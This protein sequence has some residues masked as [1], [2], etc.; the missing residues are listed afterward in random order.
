MEHRSFS[1]DSGT[2]CPVCAHSCN[3]ATSVS[4]LDSPDSR[5]ATICIN[6]S[7]VLLFNK[8][9]TLREPT[10]DEMEV[11]M[12][13]PKNAITIACMRAMI[14]GLRPKA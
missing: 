10:K 13:E 11:I 8:D 5:S 2:T 14:L 6:C 9:L 7:S 3:E 4:G 12:S 1:L